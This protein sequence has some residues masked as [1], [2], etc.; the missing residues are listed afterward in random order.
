[1][2]DNTTKKTAKIS[3]IVFFS[4]KELFV[5][6][7]A[8]YGMYSLFPSTEM[9]DIIL[10][11]AGGTTLL[12][13]VLTHLKIKKVQLERSLE[14]NLKAFDRNVGSYNEEVEK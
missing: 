9:K 8:C 10:F 3:V 12:Q 4:I 13:I 5:E 14:A 6:Y 2:S 7:L 1:M 11:L